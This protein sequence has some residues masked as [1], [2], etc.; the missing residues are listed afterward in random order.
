MLHIYDM[1]YFF[2]DQT[3]LA[4]WPNR[5]T[6][7]AGISF[8]CYLMFFLRIIKIRIKYSFNKLYMNNLY[9]N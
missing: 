8:G 2:V 5:L 3:S 9:L 1:Y 4:Q 7:D 6:V